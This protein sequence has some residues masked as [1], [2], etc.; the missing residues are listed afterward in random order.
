MVGHCTRPVLSPPVTGET[1][2]NMT[3]DGRAL[4]ALT[5]LDM[6]DRVLKRLVDKFAHAEGESYAALV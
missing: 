2:T 6:T 4:L 1:S 5:F 3:D